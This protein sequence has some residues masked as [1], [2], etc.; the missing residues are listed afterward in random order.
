MINE[1]EIIKNILFKL[2][3]WVLDKKDETIIISEEEIHSQDTTYV[4]D[5][6]EIL[7]KNQD[8]EIS[9]LDYNKKITKEEILSF[10]NDATNYALS[11]TQLKKFPENPIIDTAL[12]FWAAGLIWRKYDVRVNNNIDESYP[13]GYGDSLII[14]AKEMLKPFKNYKLSIF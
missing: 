2:D 14:Q 11:Y 7:L 3:G 8:N 9:D 10:Y 5:N 12:Y 1:S 4:H 13:I 6:L